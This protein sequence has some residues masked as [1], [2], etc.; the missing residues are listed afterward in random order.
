MKKA[1]GDIITLHMY[2]KYHNHIMYVPEIWNTTDIIFC[3]F[4]PFFA[5]LPHYRPQKT[6]IWNKSIKTWRYPITHVYHK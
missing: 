4:G 1:S 3:H 6:K 2:N 5:L